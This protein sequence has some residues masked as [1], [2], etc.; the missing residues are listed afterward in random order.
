MLACASTVAP[1]SFQA[2]CQKEIGSIMQKQSKVPQESARAVN[3]ARAAR[4]CR[5][6]F[7]RGLTA[8]RQRNNL[9]CPLVQKSRQVIT[10]PLHDSAIAIFAKWRADKNGL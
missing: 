3:P 6:C 5:G 4:R 2:N 7:C 9:S 1:T 8:P 10:A